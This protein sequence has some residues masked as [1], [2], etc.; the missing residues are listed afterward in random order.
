MGFA[1][2]PVSFRRFAVLGEAPA[3]VD[4]SLVDTLHEHVL[5]ESEGGVPQEIE[6]GWS[7]G[8][9]V[10]DASFSFEQNV[11]ADALHFA[12]RVDT[13]QVPGELKKAYALIEEESV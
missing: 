10:L 8:R 5:R 11:F 6:Y 13:N 7:G 9:H 2:G 4:Q 3:S 1:S 12:L